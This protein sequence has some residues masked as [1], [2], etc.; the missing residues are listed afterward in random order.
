MI[1]NERDPGHPR[2]GGAEIH[3]Y[4]IFSRLADRG[5]PVKH[6]AT[7]FPGGATRAE[8]RGIDIERSRSLAAYYLGMPGR[9]RRASR[10]NE[11]DLV[12]ECLNKVPFF[13]PLY[14]GKPV[15]ALCH[16]LFGEVAF[17]QAPFPIAAG[18]WTLERGLPLAYG[19]C[20]FVAISE[21][22]RDDL[23][24]RGLRADQIDISHPG[25]DRPQIAVDPATERPCRVAYFGR[26]EAY[27]RVDLLLEAAA[28]LSERFPTLE[29]VIIGRGP[30]RGALEKRATALGL[31]AKVR[32]LGYLSN[33]DRDL[34][35]ASARACAF[36]SS[37][38]GWGLTVIEAAALGT[39]VVASDAPGL[40]DSV[41]DGETG[42]LVPPNDA[43]A[44]AEGLARLLEDSE[45]A[46]RM[47]S[48]ALAWSENFNW[49]RAA[50]EM[51][52]AIDAALRPDSHATP[53]GPA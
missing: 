26:L 47:R 44:L 11:F 48:A 23:I 29:V 3:V 34:E 15:L 43:R 1:L 51:A 10:G 12:I 40:R 2:A 6:L 45:E 18:V 38:E 16:H 21:S 37:K 32:F 25:I 28:I 35:I 22:T 4:E 5:Y 30:E 42:L 8:D 9:L 46:R 27:K 17:S 24:D 41:R 20:P 14:A 36:P 49:S 13:A 53:V 19:G 31:D 33:E 52:T 39:P 7:G 50:D